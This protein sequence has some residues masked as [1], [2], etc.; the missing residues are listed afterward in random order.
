MTVLGS[1]DIESIHLDIGD[2]KN[3]ILSIA[4]YGDVH[5]DGLVLMYNNE[6][7]TLH[8]F[9]EEARKHNTL[10]SWNGDEFDV[11]L[12][13][14]RLR[15]HGIDMDYIE[16]MPIFL[17]CMRVHKFMLRKQEVA[18]TLNHVAQKHLKEGKLPFDPNRTL[19]Y[20][21]ERR[22]ELAEYNLNDAVLVWKLNKNF[23]YW[24]TFDGIVKKAVLD[25]YNTRKFAGISA[26][27]DGGFAWW[28]PLMGL[29][30]QFC[31]KEGRPIPTW[32][33]DG[34]KAL[35][36]QMNVD[37]PGGFVETPTPGHHKNVI[38]F[39][40][41]SLY[42][43]IIQTFNLGFDTDDP[44]GDIVSPCG[45]FRSSPR[46]VVAAILD[47]IVQERTAVKD[48]HKKRKTEGA[49][50]EELAALWGKI[51]ALKIFHNSFYG[52]FYAPFSPLYNYNSA[53]TITTVGQ[54]CVKTM[55][56]K[57]REMGLEVIAGDTD[58]TYVKVPHEMFNKDSALRLAE[59][60]TLHIRM[61]LKER[62]NVDF[63]GAFDFKSLI[64]D[65]ATWKKKFYAR[66]EAGKPIADMELK[67]YVRGNTP[68]LQR[69][70]QRRVF[71]EMFE[72]RD[73]GVM[74]TQ[75]KEKFLAGKDYTGLFSW[76]Q[77]HSTRGNTAQVRA[78]KALV[79][80]GV[81]LMKFE[82]VGFLLIGKGK[83]RRR[84]A[85]HWLPD[86][87]IEWLYEGEMALR[88][89]IEFLSREEA[90]RMWDAMVKKLDGAKT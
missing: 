14:A 26:K 36:A 49:N 31:E 43:T 20:F 54:E 21:K 79:E 27:E 15:Q 50:E 67:G 2:P 34:E 87:A 72:G 1:F 52:Q 75:E 90:E 51:E 85:A 37:R 4:F 62:Y 5:P 83:N 65:M 24:D 29:V 55:L 32:P 22:E 6:E 82:Q 30:R 73:I 40:F 19:Q 89:E 33:S 13:R 69:Y 68:G 66:R 46:S 23:G 7:M 47:E 53:K 39:D 84:L 81:E 60:L 12:L 9:I 44:Q 80:A 18:N 57:M 35:R 71:E 70:I 42:P 61:Y 8:R 74:L 41:K 86:S 48:E 11:P 10:L 78:K 63:V 58:S 3:R 77:V 38:E 56:A 28:R 64:S 45:R 88:R 25:D 76:M 17:D 59:E 16:K